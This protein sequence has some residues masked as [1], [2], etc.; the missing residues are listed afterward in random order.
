MSSKHLLDP[1]LYPLIEAS[2]PGFAFSEET[3]PWCREQQS[4]ALVIGDAKA[5]GV[6]RREIA[7]SGPDGDIRCLVYMPENT[8]GSAYLHIHGGGYIIGSADDSDQNNIDVASRLG[9]VVVSVDY[10]LAPEV[11][12]P[13]PLEDCYAGLVWLHEN[14]AELGVDRKRIGVGGESAGGGLAAALAILARDRGQYAICHQHLTYP[15]LDNLTGSS[16][17]K[18]DPLVGE[19][20]WTRAHNQFG[21]KSFLGDA[22]PIAPQ[23]PSR[24]ENYEGLPPT[25]MFT[26]ALDLFRDENIAYAQN[27]LKAGV[28][29][30]IVLYAG[31]CHAFQLIPGAKLGERFK[32]DYIA[33]LALGLAM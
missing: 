8:S 2:P 3:L 1:Q 15:M 29:T 21:W 27:L 18:G 9:T 7:V 6:E 30:D 24:L 33:G 14:A 4:A 11:S 23:V 19:F 28:P 26:G 10:R 17:Y 25:W 13:G 22:E 16:G 5:A 31:A 32:T 12:I 20:V